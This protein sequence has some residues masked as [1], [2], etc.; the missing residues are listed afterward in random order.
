[1]AV[2][3]LY[4]RIKIRVAVFKSNH[5]VTLGQLRLEFIVSRDSM[6]CSILIFKFNNDLNFVFSQMSL[7]CTEK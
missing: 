3:N 2:Q 6:V 7:K 1:M 4:V 5:F